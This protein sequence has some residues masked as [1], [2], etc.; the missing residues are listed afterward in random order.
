MERMTA[1]E[2]A[3]LTGGSLTGPA[4]A[5]FTSVST[6]TRSIAPGALFIALKGDNFNGNDFAAEA[7]AKGAAGVLVSE[8]KR[9]PGKVSVITVKDT[10]EALKALA[11][12]YLKKFPALKIAGVTGSNGKT[13]GKDMA[14]QLLSMKYKTLK[15]EG[16]FNNAIG[17]P[18][19]VLKLDA[20]YGALVLEYGTN[21]KGEI[22]D[23]CGIVSPEAAVVTGI[24]TAHIENFLTREGILLEKLELIRSIRN[25]GAAVFNADDPLLLKASSSFKNVLLF[26]TAAGND[27]SAEDAVSGIAGS[28]FTL[29]MRGKKEKVSLPVPGAHNISNAL[30]A[31]GLAYTF[32]LDVTM[33]ASGLS[34][35]S[36]ESKHRLAAVKTGGIFFIDD[37]YNANPESM[38]GAFSVLGSAGAGRK[39][40][41]LG[42]MA[43]LG[44][45]SAS[46]H[47]ETGRAAGAAGLDLLVTVGNVSRN[48][49]FGAIEAGMESGRTVHFMD[50][51]EAAGFLIKNLKAGDTVLVKGSRR[52]KMEE[53]IWQFSGRE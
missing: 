52:M 30:A 6:D 51:E 37:A 42:D 1:A 50:K 3:A 43:E 10:G 25:G 38:K 48:I 23:L 46:L 49:G 28:V 47:L 8:A 41:V 4:G 26:G 13:T 22:Q 31:A 39:I 9:I 33:I 16:S 7:A 14:G 19:T 11:R 15:P 12:G 36:P 45:E 24:G 32:G 35:Y 40:A 5:G 29:S 34:V 20:S 2:I 53:I 27:I 21:H 17:L 18:L 44:K